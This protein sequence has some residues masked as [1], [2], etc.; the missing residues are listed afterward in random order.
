M[1]FQMNFIVF[2]AAPKP[3]GKNIILCAA[4]S[5]GADFDAFLE[6]YTVE[7]V[8]GNLGTL[9][10]V[11]YLRSSV[12]LNRLFQTVNAEAITHYVR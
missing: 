3:L 11:E 1:L 7:N 12:T 10:G 6:Q 5:I 4:K 9:V 8:A 2:Q